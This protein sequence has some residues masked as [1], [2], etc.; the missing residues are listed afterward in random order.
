MSEKPFMEAGEAWL[1]GGGPKEDQGLGLAWAKSV[2]PYLKNK[3]KTK[4]RGVLLKW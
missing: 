1:L 3:L 4:R 2:R